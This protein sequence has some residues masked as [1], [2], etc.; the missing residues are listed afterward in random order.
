M[1]VNLQVAG[2]G[3]GLPSVDGPAPAPIPD[4]CITCGALKR[5]HYTAF[6][7]FLP[8]SET[9]CYSCQL[10]PALYIEPG[11]RYLICAP[12]APEAPLEL[13]GWVLA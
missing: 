4:P 6:H 3:R 9:T 11:S 8:M 7:V 2:A 12:C 1:T 10:R 13:P 5:D